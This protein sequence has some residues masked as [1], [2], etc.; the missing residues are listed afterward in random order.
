MDFGY[1]SDHHYKLCYMFALLCCLIMETTLKYHTWVVCMW[2][3]FGLYVVCMWY[4]CGLY[5]TVCARKK[6]CSS[7]GSCEFKN[8]LFIRD[9][10]KRISS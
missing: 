4:V 6:G 7:L 5:S 9:Q 8:W 10:Y 2:S 1:F 3:V